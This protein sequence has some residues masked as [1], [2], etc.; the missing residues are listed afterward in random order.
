MTTEAKN[1]C[2]LCLDFDGVTHPEPCHPE[3]E[4]CYLKRIEEVLREYPSVDIVISSSWRN[5]Y[6][7]QELRDFFAPDLAGRVVGMT[8]S[9][10][11]PSSNWLP[12]HAPKF[13]RE[14]EIETWMKENRSWDTPWL[15]VDDRPYWFRPDSSNLLVT[16]SK[17]GFTQ[18]DQATLRAMLQERL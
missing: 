13:E 10:K 15:A 14:W 7:L 18:D 6:S 17:T 5:H 16:Q 9:I 4:F 2:V 8:P 1:S 12:G 3:Q 11:R